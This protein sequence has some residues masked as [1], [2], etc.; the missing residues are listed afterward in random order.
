MMPDGWKVFND[1]QRMIIKGVEVINQ[2]ALHQGFQNLMAP[3]NRVAQGKGAATMFS[4][5]NQVIQ[6]G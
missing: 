3:G 4:Q 6:T 5:G 1:G 2:V